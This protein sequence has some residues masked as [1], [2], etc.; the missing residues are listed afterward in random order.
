MRFDLWVQYEFR[1]GDHQATL[2]SVRVRG[3]C[4]GCAVQDAEVVEAESDARWL[5]GVEFEALVRNG[6]GEVL[7]MASRDACAEVKRWEEEDA[8]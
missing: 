5:S 7:A 6:I 4:D 1:L 3:F 8:A 2:W